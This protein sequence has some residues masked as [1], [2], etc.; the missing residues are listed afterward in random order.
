VGTRNRMMFFAIVS[1]LIT[2]CSSL[3]DP[4][5]RITR[6]QNGSVWT[7]SENL[8]LQNNNLVPDYSTIDVVF[9]LDVIP[10]TNDPSCQYPA[11]LV[12][13]RD[14]GGSFIG[15]PAATYVTGSCTSGPPIREQGFVWHPQSLGL[16][17]LSAHI[18]VLNDTGASREFD[19]DSVTVCVVSD[20]FHPP[21]DIP[22]G[23]SDADCH[24][25]ILPTLTP[26]PTA[27]AT[28]VSPIPIPRNPNQH[29]GSGCGQYSSQ[30]RCNL[31]GCS[32]NPQNSTC[33]VNP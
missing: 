29:G 5:V 19:S 15:A 4:H 8:L 24:P 12:E 18:I 32:W 21:Q 31:A 22:V 20:P 17:T 30:S 26:I 10:P 3:P 33:S 7:L 1:V 6:P 13:P 9:Q 28:P 27:T 25:A 16:H 2:G 11:V 23:R 14:N